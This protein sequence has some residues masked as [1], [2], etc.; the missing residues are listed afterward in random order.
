VNDLFQRATTYVVSLARVT[1]FEWTIAAVLFLPLNNFADIPRFV[2]RVNSNFLIYFQR[3]NTKRQADRGNLIFLVCV[4]NMFSA[5]GTKEGRTSGAVVCCCIRRLLV[6]TS[7]LVLLVS[8]RPRRVQHVLARVQDCRI[9]LVVHQLVRQ[10]ACALLPQPSV[11]PLLQPLPVLLLQ[12]L[13]SDRFARRSFGRW[14]VQCDRSSYS[15]GE[16]ESYS[17]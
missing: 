16:K 15:P 13:F 14:T 8:L 17:G 11:P 1:R 4:V 3:R 5:G 10:S 9:L 7:R 6:A 2:D 12:L